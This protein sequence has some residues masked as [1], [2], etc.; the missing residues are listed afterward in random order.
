MSNGDRFVDGNLG[1]GASTPGG[2][3]EIKRVRNSDR[4]YGDDRANPAERAEN[5]DKKGVDGNPGVGTTT[6]AEKSETNGN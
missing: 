3:A 6:P 2:K 5:N 1:A 4:Y